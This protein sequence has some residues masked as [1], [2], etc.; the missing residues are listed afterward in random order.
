M[1]P[2][3]LC[4]EAHRADGRVWAVYFKRRWRLAPLVNVMVP[5]RTVYCGPKARQPRAYLEGH[6]SAVTRRG[7][8][9]VI[10]A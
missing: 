8:L 5:V 9:L 4:F 2:F 10:Q 7:D 3:K 1:T 6:A